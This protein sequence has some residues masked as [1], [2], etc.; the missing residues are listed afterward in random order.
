MTYAWPCMV[1]KSTVDPSNKYHGHLLLANFIT[2]MAIHKRI[3]RQVFLSLMK[4]NT[5]EARPIVRAA[6]DIMT[7][8]MTGRLEDG[9]MVLARVCRT[10]ILEEGHQIT[11]LINMMQV[12][13]W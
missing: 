12:W 8:S 5:A 2:K 10:I 1:T 6:L 3:I 4:A 13:F 11:H 9:K 7:N